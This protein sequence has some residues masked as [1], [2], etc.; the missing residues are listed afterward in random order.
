[1]QE[2]LNNQPIG[3]H[4]IIIFDGSCGACS[5]FVG[6]KKAFFEKHGF[7]VAP[8]QDEWVRKVAGLDESALSQAIHLRTSHGEVLR[9][10]DFVQYLTGKVWWLAPVHLLLRIQILK[11]LFVKLYDFIA[12]R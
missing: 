7:T 10:V 9:G 12:K 5:T 6:R 8:F 4:G 3:K 1:M 11:P 2:D